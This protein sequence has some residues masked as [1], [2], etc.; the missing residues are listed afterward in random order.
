[1][2]IFISYRRRFGG[3]AYAHFL[4]QKLRVLGIRVFFDLVSLQDKNS[5]YQEE[6]RKNIEDCDYFLLLLQ[7][8]MFHDLA[9]DD[10]IK[11][12]RLAHKLK[13]EI[14]AIPV[15][16][17]FNWNNEQPL[18][19]ELDAVG[20]PYLQLMRCL[21]FEKIDPFIDDLIGRFTN[22]QEQIAY[23]QFLHS[24]EQSSFS[25]FLVPESSI[26]NVP[27]GVRWD[28]AKRVSLL[29]VGG[30]SILGIYQRTVSDLLAQGVSFRFITIDPKGKSRKDIEEKK[31]YS[32]YSGQDK[33]YLK[34]RQNRIAAVIKN[35][36]EHSPHAFQNNIGFRVTD[37]HITMT[38]QWV[39][40]EREENSYIF[41]SFLPIVAINQQHSHSLSA[42]ITR[43][44]PLYN[45]FATQFETIWRHAKIVI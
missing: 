23:Y 40:A 17:S 24:A 42:L 32:A 13:K 19:C 9:G 43:E 8:Q 21:S 7:P 14:I 30:G 15:E 2:N 16:E 1:M 6:I 28:H 25:G 34:Q 20:L 27:L 18:P 37:E 36:Q 10:L 39:E 5:D 45:F 33:G 35:M 26:T 4:C 11:E 44:S 3:K 41:V 29:S 22:H 12:I 31:M 38:L